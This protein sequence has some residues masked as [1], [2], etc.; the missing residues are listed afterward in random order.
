MKKVYWRISYND[1]GIY[2]ALKKEIWKNDL[3][4]EEWDNLKLS[5][6]FTWLKTPTFYNENCYSYFTELGYKLFIQNTYSVIIKYLDERKIKVEEKEI[7]DCDINIVYSDE[8][9]IV[10]MQ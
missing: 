2:N 1:I 10:V 7:D 9:Q 3:P 4:K 8:H 6:A 5:N